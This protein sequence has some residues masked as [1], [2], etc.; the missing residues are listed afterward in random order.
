MTT[1][2]RVSRLMAT[3]LTVALS[4]SF[5]A[6]PGLG[7]ETLR[8]GK[9]IALPFDFTPLDVG[10]AKGFDQ[11]GAPQGR[12]SGIVEHPRLEQ[13]LGAFVKGLEGRPVEGPSTQGDMRAL[14]KILLVQRHAP[15]APNRR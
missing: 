10:I 3:G 6:G 15:S 11:L 13:S 4:L 7:A 1:M 2:Q 12:R 14:P 8:V 5:G 9:A